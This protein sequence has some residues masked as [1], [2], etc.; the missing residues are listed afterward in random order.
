MPSLPRRST[1]SMRPTSTAGC[2]S[3]SPA[4]HTSPACRTALHY[5]C[6]KGF[7]DMVELLVAAGA[8][9]THDGDSRTPMIKVGP[10]PPQP[11]HIDSHAQALES[12]HFPCVDILIDGGFDCGEPDGHGNTVWPDCVTHSQVTTAAPALHRCARS[13]RAVRVGHHGHGRYQRSK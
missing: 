6:A 11:Q 4:K 8:V 10:R 7:S 1:T 9:S 3:P 12:S 13:G 2:V 5:A